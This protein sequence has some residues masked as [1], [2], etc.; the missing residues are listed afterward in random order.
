MLPTSISK[1]LSSTER[2]KKYNTS[3][4]YHWIIPT[5]H[6]FYPVVTFSTPLSPPKRSLFL[7]E[8]PHE[9]WVIQVFCPVKNGVIPWA[10]RKQWLRECHMHGAALV[11]LTLQISK[12][13]K[14]KSSFWV[15]LW[16]MGFCSWRIYV[17]VGLH[18]HCFPN[19][20]R[21]AFAPSWGTFI[22][23]H[24]GRWCFPTSACSQFP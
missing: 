20:S 19:W 5:A 17:L 22:S 8:A 11:C 9:S 21:L 14:Q 16:R 2:W 24:M 7:R 15:C 12:G 4:C 23:V 3:C 6:H 10:V 13:K 1:H 18:C